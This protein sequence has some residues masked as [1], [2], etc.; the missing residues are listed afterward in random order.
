M[1]R[2]RKGSNVR[3]AVGR[4]LLSGFCRYQVQ[5]RN[6]IGAPFAWV[7]G[8][9]QPMAPAPVRQS[10][11]TV[12]A[13]LVSSFAS[14]KFLWH[15]IFLAVL[16]A[17]LICGCVSPRGFPPS[18][19][20]QNFDQVD[21]RLFRGAQPSHEA[22]LGL[23][24]QGVGLIVCL[25]EDPPPGEGA[26]CVEAGM[27]LVQVGMS[28]TRLPTREQVEQALGAIDGF[29]VACPSNRVF[30][31]CQYGCDRTGTVVACYRVRQGW[32]AEDA[33]REAKIYGLSPFF[34]GLR[35][36]LGRL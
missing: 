24:G 18:H 16:T 28:G 6:P 25:R 17:M 10:N 15:W 21:S 5:R 7:M 8:N 12:A 29:L 36:F 33:Y 32:T 34:A 26:W 30:V 2:S 13:E 9:Y 14:V 23:A 19:G 22:I 3:S 4:F 20:I 27:Q 35:G 1:G 31:H 11:A